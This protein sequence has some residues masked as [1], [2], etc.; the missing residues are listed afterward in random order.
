MYVLP[1]RNTDQPTFFFSDLIIIINR[2]ESRDPV[3]KTWQVVGSLKEEKRRRGK[4]QLSKL[5][6]KRRVEERGG[7]MCLINSKKY[8]FLASTMDSKTGGGKHEDSPGGLPS[9][10]VA[11][12]MGGRTGGRPFEIER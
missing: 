7:K 8:I 12:A 9:D 3:K 1:L 4:I 2:E 6:K 5:E 11:S 10:P